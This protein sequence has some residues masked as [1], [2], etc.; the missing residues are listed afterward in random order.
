MAESKDPIEDYSGHIEN[1]VLGD[2]N[3]AFTMIRIEGPED[4]TQKATLVMAALSE[5]TRR[6]ARRQRAAHAWYSLKQAAE[7]S[8]AIAAAL[9]EFGA[10][11]SPDESRVNAAWQVIADSGA[12]RPFLVTTLR[13]DLR[14]G[15]PQ[16]V[17]KSFH[18]LEARQEVRDSLAA[19]ISAVRAH[20]DEVST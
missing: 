5:L 14:V 10:G 11:S 4:L 15:G 18:F 16:P 3:R 12:L 1:R 8:G 9:G 17:I 6:V 20:L 7:G 2:V 13:R 19:F